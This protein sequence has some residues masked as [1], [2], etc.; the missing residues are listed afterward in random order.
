MRQ[1]YCLNE[2]TDEQSKFILG[3]QTYFTQVKE[4]I[5]L[6]TQ[7]KHKQ[8]FS[9][10]NKNKS[11]STITSLDKLK[12]ANESEDLKKFKNFLNEKDENCSNTTLLKS[13]DLILTNSSFSV[14]KN[15]T[16]MSLSIEEWRIKFDQTN[17]DL[18]DAMKGSSEHAWWALIPPKE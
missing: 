12:N 6:E 17:S 2:I 3:Q 10:A 7:F 8:K 11:S 15:S 18:M 4:T 13:I 5:H 14:I 9:K 1:Q 16:C